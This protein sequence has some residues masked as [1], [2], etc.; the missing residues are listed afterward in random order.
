[1]IIKDWWHRAKGP[2]LESGRM[3][4]QDKHTADF[5]FESVVYSDWSNIVPAEL[6]NMLQQSYKTQRSSQTE[7][8]FS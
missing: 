2:L 8:F 5:Y 4:H 6:K 3:S 1:M 7:L